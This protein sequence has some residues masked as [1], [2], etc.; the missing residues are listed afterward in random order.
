MSGFILF[1]VSTLTL[2]GIYAVITLGLSIE[3]GTGGLWDL[4]IVTF[5]ALGAYTYTLLTAGPPSPQNHY[6]FGAHLPLVVA[7]LAAGAVGVGAAVLVGRPTLKLKAEY[8]LITT[9]AFAEVLR[10]VIIN[11]RWLTNGTGGLYRLGQPAKEVF[12]RRSYPWAL[13]AIVLL[14]VLLAYLVV[15][16]TT[17]SPF[18]RS[19]KAL[20]ENEAL[21][22]TAGVA[23]YPFYAKAYAMAGF[24]AAIGGVL[25]VW[26]NTVIL[27]SQFTADISFF[28]WIAV[29]IGGIGNH[30]GALLGVFALVLFDNLMRF[31]NFSS[32]TAVMVASLRFAFMGL[33]L[34]LVLRLRP[35]GIL[36]E[37]KVTFGPTGERA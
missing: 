24:L 11:E 36:P 26:Y 15:Q 35:T 37:R 7:A 31:I 22:A 2:A 4:G 9:F 10:Q 30:R 33:V 6:I 23:A 32:D 8:F 16:R 3:A 12:D 20:R 25:Y 17:R 1:L 14:V 18:G 28:V 13:L 5:V 27:P 21:A 34:L 19:L 29:V